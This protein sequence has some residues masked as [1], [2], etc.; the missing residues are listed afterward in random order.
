MLSYIMDT[1]PN[2]IYLLFFIIY[3]LMEQNK[4]ITSLEKT[5]MRLAMDD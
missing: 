4:K 3:L 5:L 1:P 2:Y